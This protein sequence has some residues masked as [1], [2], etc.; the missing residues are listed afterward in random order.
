MFHRNHWTLNPRLGI[1]LL[2]IELKS[3]FYN[4]LIGYALLITY[5]IFLVIS[6][7]LEFNLLGKEIIIINSINIIRIRY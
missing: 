6:G 2:N 3:Q 1:K 4:L 7:A 5:A